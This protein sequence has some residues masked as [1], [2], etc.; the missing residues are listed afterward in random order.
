MNTLPQGNRLRSSHDLDKRQ[1]QN[2]IYLGPHENEIGII[3]Q[4]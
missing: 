1:R 3:L 4:V 2:Q